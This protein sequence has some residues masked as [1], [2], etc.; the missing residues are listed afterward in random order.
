MAAF[1]LRRAAN[2][3]NSKVFFPR[4]FSSLAVESNSWFTSSKAAN[5][6]VGQRKTAFVDVRSPELYANGHIPGARNIHEIF[7]HLAM[8]DEAGVKEL[9]KTFKELFRRAG[10]CGDER[11]TVYDTAY[12]KQFGAS[13]RGFYL[14]TLLGHPDVSVL[15]GGWEKWAQ[16]PTNPISTNQPTTDQRG[17]F[18]ANWNPLYWSDKKDVKRIVQG[19]DSAVLLDVRD[20]EEWKGESSSPYGKHFAPRLGRIP[21]SKHINWR[22]FI[23][24]GKGVS[25]LK[26]PQE[27]CEIMENAG[28]E[29][30]ERVVV[31]CFKG[32]RASSTLMNLQ[33][34]GYNNVMNYYASWNEWSR[35]HSLEIED[36]KLY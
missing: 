19:K 20:D 18:T 30:E 12:D 35:D 26:H 9:Q 29:K 32:A 15:D 21:R 34:A 13:C 11:V 8:S 10:I 25:T 4:L 36:R 14:F 24:S 1:L 7:T 22:Q 5:E 16:D 3:I 27:V 28:I 33:R 2:S 17:T 6:L 31:L 23:E